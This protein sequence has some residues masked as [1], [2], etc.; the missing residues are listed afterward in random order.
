M[1]LLVTETRELKE[2]PGSPPSYAIFSHR[3][4]EEEVTFKDLS[5]PDVQSMEGYSKFSEACETAQFLGFDYLWIDTCCIDKSDNVELSEAINSMYNWY[6]NSGICFAY[7]DDVTRKNLSEEF[8]GSEWFS[9]G[10]T[11]QE[12][13]AP[14]EVLFFDRN[15]TLL[16]TRASLA[17]YVELASGI[18]RILL[19]TRRFDGVSVAKKMSW[20][21]RRVTTRL[22]DEAYCLMGMFNVN[23][24][25]I[26]GEGRRA[27]IRLQEE[28]LKQTNDHSIFAWGFRSTLVTPLH[29]H[30]STANTVLESKRT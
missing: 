24:P 29:S 27:F 30:W 18:E 13:I 16:G 5:R 7:L 12:L 20:A 10:W 26:Y 23:M 9:R 3:W 28:I 21:S 1:R 19:L 25:A 11:L 6:M 4:R 8:S 17:T 22:E 14:A 15:W 2:F